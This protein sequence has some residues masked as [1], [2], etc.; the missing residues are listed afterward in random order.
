MAAEIRP[1]SVQGPPVSA[2]HGRFPGS[3]RRMIVLLV[4]VKHPDSRT[5]LLAALMASI[6]Y[7]RC[8]PSG[9]AAPNGTEQ[10]AAGSGW[11]DGM[12]RSRVYS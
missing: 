11:M 2:G 10:Y 9:R 1:I 8:V 12:I 6:G 4:E 5:A 3:N 7:Q